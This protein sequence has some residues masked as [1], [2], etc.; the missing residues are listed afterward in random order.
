MSDR[1]KLV[2]EIAARTELAFSRSDPSA[3]ASPKDSSMCEEAAELRGPQ[4]STLTPTIRA[5]HP[6]VPNCVRG[7]HRRDQV[8][9]NLF[10]QQ[11]LPV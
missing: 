2:R 10:V 1:V 3:G 4:G 9:R 8:E 7:N 11:F 6:M 5:E